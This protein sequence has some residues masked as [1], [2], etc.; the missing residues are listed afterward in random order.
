MILRLLK[1]VTDIERKVLDSPYKQDV[2]GSSPSLPTIL[3]PNPFE[4]GRTAINA[5]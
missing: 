4:D 1:Q 2:G 3:L 5:G